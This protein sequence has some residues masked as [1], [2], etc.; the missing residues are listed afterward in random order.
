LP[1]TFSVPIV[2][3]VP[4]ANELPALINRLPTVPMPERTAA[5]LTVVR[6]EL[7]IEPSTSSTPALTLVGPD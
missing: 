4:G 1:W 7:A 3:G 2:F 5:L 6:L